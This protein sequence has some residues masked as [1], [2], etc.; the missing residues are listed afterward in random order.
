MEALRDSP[1]TQLE[2][3]GALGQGPLVLKPYDPVEHA[4][5]PEEDDQDISG[6]QGISDATSGNEHEP[7][8]DLAFA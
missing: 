2:L 1:C 4:T 6:V 3:R 7:D 8:H 5:L